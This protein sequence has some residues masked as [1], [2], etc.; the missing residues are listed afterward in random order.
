MILITCA[1]QL[2]VGIASV[3]GSEPSPLTGFGVVTLASLVPVNMVLL[4]GLL[5]P[6]AVVRGSQKKTSKI[7]E[8]VEWFDKT[9]YTETIGGLRALVPLV[10]IMNG[11]LRFVLSG[12]GVQAATLRVDKRE[13]TAPATLALFSAQVTNQP[14]TMRLKMQCSAQTRNTVVNVH[15]TVR[16]GR[17]DEGVVFRL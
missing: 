10:I 8:V 7:A 3:S 12:A 2:G 14:A 13:V 9:P 4:L 15:V 6:K 1:P 11:L 5:L 17:K 16:Q